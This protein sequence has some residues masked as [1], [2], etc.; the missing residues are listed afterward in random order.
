MF[1]INR[2]NFK[3]RFNE[4]KKLYIAVI[5][6]MIMLNII[7]IFSYIGT[8]NILN[9]NIDAAAETTL[10]KTGQNVQDRITEC[11][12]YIRMI[13]DRLGT[14]KPV[15]DKMYDIE[16]YSQKMSAVFL[17]YYE[18][19]Y[20]EYDG[21]VYKSSNVKPKQSSHAYELAHNNPDIINTFIESNG[22][23][24]DSYI[25]ISLYDSDKDVFASMMLDANLIVRY[26]NK[27]DSLNGV[28][29]ALI[30][31]SGNKLLYSTSSSINY[32]SFSQSDSGRKLF[33][34]MAADPAGKVSLKINGQ[35]CTGY[36]R[37][38]IGSWNI[39]LY[40]SRSMLYK[41]LY[42]FNSI[43][44]GVIVL[45]F[46]LFI[47][48]FMR[49]YRNSLELE[50]ALKTRSAFLTNM[51]HE[52]RTPLN[53]IIGMSEIL[54]RRNVHGAARN[55]VV[56][57]HN[58]GTGLLAIINDILDYSKMES[59]SF[60]IINDEYDLPGLVAEVIS[61]VSFRIK[62]KDVR[63][64]VN[65]NPAV[66]KRLIGDEVRIKQILVNLLG[67]A[68][69]FTQHGYIILSIDWDFISDGKTNLTFRVMDTGIGISA[70]ERKKLFEEFSQ[71]S[72]NLAKNH[73]T[74]LGL[75]ISKNL[76]LQMD[77]SIELESTPGK[78]S[79]FTVK[80]KN[81]VD[82]YSPVAA[83]PD[84]G[85][86]IG[87]YEQD[88]TLAEHLGV[89]LEMLHVKYS[90]I[91]SHT[92]RSLFK[93]L[94]HV[95]FRSKW[96]NEVGR[97]LGSLGLSPVCIMLTEMN[98]EIDDGSHV[99]KLM[100]NLYGL[101]IADALNGEIK[102]FDRYS[103]FDTGEIV[104]IADARALL[105]DDN[106]TNMA[107]A[108][109]I[110]AEY[111]ITIDTAVDGAQAVEMVKQNRYDIVFMDN[112]M[113]V[114]D[115]IEATRRIREMEGDY[116]KNLPIIALTALAG[117]GDKERF[118]G[119]GF[120]EFLSKPIDLTKMDVL[121]HKFLQNKI[122]DIYKMSEPAENESLAPVQDNMIIDTEAGLRQ[123]GSN[124]KSYVDILTI[125]VQD[126]EKR[127]SQ[128]ISETS[129]EK[130]T[131]NFHAIKGSSANVGAYQLNEMAAE[132][133]ALGKAGDELAVEIKLEQFLQ[134]L[135]L[136]I[137]TAKEYINEYHGQK[138]SS[139]GYS[140]M[141]AAIY[142]DEIIRACTDMD[143]IKIENIYDKITGYN[144]PDNIMKLL[145]NIKL[146]SFEYDYDKI[147]EYAQQLKNN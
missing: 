45:I 73:G 55:D 62:S 41:N 96:K 104:S 71:G 112:M 142:V 52:I 68:V 1:S 43:Q 54:L 135:D 88:I 31:D 133:E 50:R 80:V 86:Y 39:V 119:L 20:A 131:I 3:E 101:Q 51:S 46:I 63:L 102:Y 30:I 129:I 56:S 5:V 139:K 110:L 23:V 97:I 99:K 82:N 36:Y 16:E 21:L 14:A 141:V 9:K 125:Y 35:R 128:L 118:Q 98:E 117:R 123:L 111:N 107:V 137:Q 109:G 103:G 136:T 106:I 147:K 57:I 8:T 38:F 144:Y 66:P 120:D 61:L 19:I 143:M 87:I 28:F 4:N 121:L 24:S 53:A 114:M 10:E 95:F 47:Y 6:I 65:I 49:S 59:G 48:F 64:L 37:S 93:D 12:L 72:S 60:Q 90:I 17:G 84:E 145:E 100:L 83:V 105:V 74:G 75:Y 89:M 94:T 91:N 33:K 70:E 18:G 138:N 2:A 140:P 25:V 26:V 11:Q 44:Y 92:N 146:A 130:N 116:Y 32:D 78:G 40:A 69:K 79:T 113:P 42:I 76:A 77:G 13:C 127:Y 29:D 34:A 67:N 115:G 7:I 122:K 124:K 134:L 22:S 126:M 27:I 15:E 132:M 85:L 81:A 58:A 108:K